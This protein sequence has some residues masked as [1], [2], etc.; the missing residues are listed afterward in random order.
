MQKGRQEGQQQKSRGIAA[1]YFKMY[2][3]ALYYKQHGTGTNTNTRLERIEDPDNSK[4]KIQ[5]SIV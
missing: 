5:L 3:R 1:P 4:K 2:H